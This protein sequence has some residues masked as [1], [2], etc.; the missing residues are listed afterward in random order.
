MSVIFTKFCLASFCH[1]TTQW[2]PSQKKLTKTKHKFV[3]TNSIGGDFFFNHPIRKN[4]YFCLFAND[5]DSNYHCWNL[6]KYIIKTFFWLRKLLGGPKVEMPSKLA[7]LQYS[8]RLCPNSEKRGDG[9]VL[10]ALTS[11]Y[12]PGSSIPDE[13]LG[14]FLS[15]SL[16]C[17]D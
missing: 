15:S 13:F 2:G 3:S 8:M 4:C 17:R 14:W 11:I 7:N 5:P 12:R 16:A 9:N 1:L 10:G 6:V